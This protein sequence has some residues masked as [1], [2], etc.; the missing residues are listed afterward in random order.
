MEK[1]RIKKDVGTVKDRKISKRAWKGKTTEIKI[2]RGRKKERMKE[3]KIDRK[4]KDKE[5][6]RER[7]KVYSPIIHFTYEVRLRNQ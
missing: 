1:K 3:R 6:E 2:V 4:K 5:R 7:E